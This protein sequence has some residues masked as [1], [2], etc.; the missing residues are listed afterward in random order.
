VYGSI[1]FAA[2]FA[3]GA[4][5]V[6][7]LAP[8]LGATMA[9]LLETPAILGISWEVAR[10]CIVRY[11]VAADASAGGLM[12]SIAFAILMLCELATAVLVFQRTPGEFLQSHASVPGA[13][14]L[15]AQVAFAVFPSTVMLF[16]REVRNA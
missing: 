3:L 13:I 11:G 12:G 15:A 10:W 8:K 2:G 6:L 9:V 7:F 16:E 4:V 14:G 5:R 1:V